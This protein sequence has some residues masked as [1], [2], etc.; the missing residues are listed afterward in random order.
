M[1]LPIPAVPSMSAISVGKRMMLRQIRAIVCIGSLALAACASG[2]SISTDVEYCCRSGAENVNSYR[3]EFEDM[4]EFLK[5]MLRDEVSMVLDSKGLEYTEGDAHAV[6][7]M[8]YVHRL[9]SKEDVER[10]VAWGTLS[11][12]GD[13]RFVAEVHAELKKSV[14]NEV[15]WSGTL[16]K[17]HNV[18]IG[19]YM[20]DA[21]ARSAMREA[22]KV[23]FADYPNRILEDY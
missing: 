16:R 21:P 4:P 13:S 7:T 6:L 8:M 19:A 2:P 14:T 5:P 12:G 9:L 3:I 10:K 15:I 1:L 18:A 20:H 17:L 23:L 11:P 22:F